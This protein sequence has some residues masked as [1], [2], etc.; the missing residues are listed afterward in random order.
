[1]YTFK[2]LRRTGLCITCIIPEILFTLFIFKFKDAQGRD[3]QDLAPVPWGFL[4]W[5][6]WSS[7]VLLSFSKIWTGM[8]VLNLGG[9]PSLS[10]TWIFLH[11]LDTQISRQ[12]SRH[13]FKSLQRRRVCHMYESHLWNTSFYWKNDNILGENNVNRCG[14]R[15]GIWYHVRLLFTPLIALCYVLPLISK[16]KLEELQDLV[17]EKH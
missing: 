8:E 12:I 15:V 14:H 3:Y 2:S 17:S 6:C 16:I 11:K 7:N 5:T 13:T 9:F 10:H 1:M 4:A